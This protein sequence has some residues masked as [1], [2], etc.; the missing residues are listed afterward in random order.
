MAHVALAERDD[1]VPGACAAGRGAAISNA[2]RKG[3]AAPARFTPPNTRGCGS[4]G[5]PPDKHILGDKDKTRG[6]TRPVLLWDNLAPGAVT[7]CRLGPAP[8]SS[9]TPR[10]R[11]G[12]SR[13]PPPARPRPRGRR[14]LPTPK[15][16]GEA[17]GSGW[18]A[19]HGCG[20]H[21][22]LRWGRA[23]LGRSR[24][25]GNRGR[26]GRGRSRGWHRAALPAQPQLPA[27]RPG[28]K[29]L[30]EPG[31]TEWGARPGWV[32][33]AASRP[34]SRSARPAG[35]PGRPGPALR[36]PAAPRSPRGDVA[37]ALSSGSSGGGR[38]SSTSAPRSRRRRPGAGFIPPAAAAP[39]TSVSAAAAA[40]RLST[41][42]GSWRLAGA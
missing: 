2:A 3:A 8:P 19:L 9:G 35:A 28:S 21:R 11:P 14:R 40:A 30:V 10:P 13:P 15:G 7:S 38:S 27:P 32:A 22:A 29:G 42:A 5:A 34:R 39:P 41:A 36:P 26:V 4:H 18:A 24:P 31:E 17:P 1:G 12:P 20:G 37:P 25:P 6:I 16:P 33:A 23:R